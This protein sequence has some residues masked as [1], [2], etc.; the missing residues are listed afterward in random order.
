[1]TIGV[2]V[3]MTIGGGTAGPLLDEFVSSHST[4]PWVML[5]GDIG[6]AEEIGKGDVVGLRLWSC[7]CVWGCSRGWAMGGV[8]DA[9]LV[10]VKEWCFVE[11]VVMSTEDCAS[12]WGRRMS[13]AG[14]GVP[15]T[16]DD[17]WVVE[18]DAERASDC[19]D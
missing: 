16:V 18:G 17:S 3:V 7:V 9:G 12:E 4:P 11:S 10:P 14:M 2:V 13:D 19:C 5:I 1:M 6:S 15:L 8:V